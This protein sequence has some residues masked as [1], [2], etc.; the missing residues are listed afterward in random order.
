MRRNLILDTCAL[1]WLVSGNKRLSDEAKREIEAAQVVYVSPISAWEVSLK[2]A[3][4]ALELPLPPLEWFNRA[5]EVHHLTL[6][7]LSV[8]VLMRA[9]ELPWHHRDPADRFIIATAKVDGLAIVTDDRQFR[10][11]DVETF[12]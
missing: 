11:Y 12:C 8:E 3:R 6:G 10:D 5:L 4:G 2:S 9:N 7:D 1:V